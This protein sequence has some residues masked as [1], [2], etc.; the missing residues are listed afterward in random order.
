MTV[1][2]QYVATNMIYI[3][4]THVN[5]S[6]NECLFGTLFLAP[7]FALLFYDPLNDLLLLNEESTND[8]IM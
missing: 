2:N 1:S 6:F 5:I 7:R 4:I 3:P 8:A